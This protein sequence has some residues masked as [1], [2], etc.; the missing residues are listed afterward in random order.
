MPKHRSAFRNRL[1]ALAVGAFGAV[2]ARRTPESAEAAG[3]AL[4]RIYRR[5]DAL[6]EARKIN[7]GLVKS[8]FVA[9]GGD[10][11]F[12]DAEGCANFVSRVTGQ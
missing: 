3:R 1:E 4:G 9:S 2:L 5:L 10:F 8:G 11:G 6:R 12:D 7:R